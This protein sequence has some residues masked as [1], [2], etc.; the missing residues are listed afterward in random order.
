MRF[1]KFLNPYKTRDSSFREYTKI[2]RGNY[3]FL[4]VIF[5]TMNVSKKD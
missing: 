1:R 3:G 4:R 5:L 2:I